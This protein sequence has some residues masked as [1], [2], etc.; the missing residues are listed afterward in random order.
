MYY[1]APEVISNQE[2]N[3]SC[4]IWSCGIIMYLLLRGKPPFY[5]SSRE[6]TIA[7][8]KAGVL[9]FSSKCRDVNGI[10]PQWR[11]VS[12]DAIDLL[13]RMLTKNPQ[14]RISAVE[15]IK[16]KWITKFNSERV[17]DDEFESHLIQVLRHLKNFRAQGILQKAVLTYIASQQT[18]AETEKKTR[19]IFSRM[20]KDNNGEIT[21]QELIEG[22]QQIYHDKA[23]AQRDAASVLRRIDVNKN[24]VVD[25]NGT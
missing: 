25:Y 17:E 1:V 6:A 11:F 13:K 3:E 12:P 19:A 24:G 15:A 4:D 7:A 9:N 2:Y 8:I 20:D 21:V 5:E 16:H 14:D 10:A 22:Y 18:D 23:R